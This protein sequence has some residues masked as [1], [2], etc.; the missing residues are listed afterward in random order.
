MIQ[1]EL[2]AA[3]FV[4]ALPLKLSADGSCKGCIFSKSPRQIP[5]KSVLV[6]VI[7][8]IH[9]LFLDMQKWL[10]SCIGEPVVDS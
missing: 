5:Y 1:S 4:I 10:I 2:V 8:K 7:V 6:I 3:K 9:E